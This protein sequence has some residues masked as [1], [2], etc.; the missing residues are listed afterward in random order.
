M[1]MANE[2]RRRFVDTTAGLLHQHGYAG[3]SL[4]GILA[5][6]GAPRGSLYYHFPGGKDQL[7]QEATSNSVATVTEFLRDCFAPDRD[8]V[9]AVRRYAAE[10]ARELSESG[11]VFGCPVA[12]LILDAIDEELARIC[13]EA[14][15]V[16]Q[17]I[18]AARLRSAGLGERADSF[19]SLVVS[20]VEGALV[21][22][23]ARR[24]ATA[25]EHAGAE[26]ASQLESLLQTRNP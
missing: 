23:R 4:N 7:V 11:Y 5:A 24:D 14:V 25:L 17:G 8:P 20:A 22:A 19:A 15:D 9:V 10:A 3:T 18:V 12:P 1:A 26:L 13:R 21:V 16:W 6:S 2:T